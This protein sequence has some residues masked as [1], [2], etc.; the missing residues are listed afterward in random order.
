[1][2]FQE[3]LRESIL[4][5]PQKELCKELFRNKKMIPLVRKKILDTFEKWKI[6]FINDAEIKDIFLL[7]SSTT[8]QYNETSDVDVNIITNLSYD[9]VHAIY[10]LLP[11][12]FLIGKH[13]VNYYLSINTEDVDRSTTLYDIKN[14]KW[15]RKPTYEK[16]V[17]PEDYALEI[18]RF[19]MDGV[20]LRIAELERDKKD[21]EKLKNIKS[22]QKS[23]IYTGKIDEDIAKKEQE[24]KADYDAIGVAHY[25]LRSF[26]Y[27]GFSD[28]VGYTFKI[29]IKN[30]INP[31][32][33]MNNVVY[34]ILD[35]YG[36]IDR[37]KDLEDKE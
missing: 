35:K 9:K 1:M 7:G 24:I 16:T 25:L 13:P 15:V 12:G 18:A 33:S 37:L 27:E 31:N 23:V 6:K 4:D 30:K 34:K 22:N 36:Y 8:Y 32:F 29:E 20:D 26:R 17:V 11:K 19:F 21:L 10:A 28:E 3:I 5:T 2:K 14:D